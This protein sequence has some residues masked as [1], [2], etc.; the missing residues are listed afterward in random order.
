MTCIV[1]IARNGIVTIGGDSAGVDGW[2]LDI[3]ADLKVFRDGPFVMGF[4]SSFRMGQLLRYA[5]PQPE[6]FE[7]VEIE[8]FM[9]TTFVNEVRETLKEGGYARKNEEAESGGTFLVGYRGRLFMIGNDYQV[10]E[11][12]SGFCAVGCARSQAIGA[13]AILT[14]TRKAPKVMVREALHVAERYSA[15]VRGPF[16]IVQTRRES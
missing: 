15:G 6:H 4:T 10:A 9:A 13:M 16:H 3:R 1:G 5:M 2:D 12:V 7:G 14:K 11:S 8:E